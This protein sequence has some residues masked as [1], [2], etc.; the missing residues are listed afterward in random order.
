MDGEEDLRLRQASGAGRPSQPGAPGGAPPSGSTGSTSWSSARRSTPPRRAPSW[1]SRPRWSSPCS[2]TRPSPSSPRPHPPRCCCARR[3][4]SRREAGSR[5]SPRSA[6]SAAT[7]SP[8]VA[9]V[10]MPDLNTSDEDAANP[11]R[12]GDRP[13]HGHRDRGSRLTCR[14]GVTR[15][16]EKVERGRFYEATE[17]LRLLKEVANPEVRRDRGGGGEPGGGPPASPTRWCAAR[18]CCRTA[19]AGMVRV[20][21]LRLRAPSRRRGA[22]GRRGRRGS[23]G[24]RGEGARRRD[25]VRRGDRHTRLHAESWAS[26]GRILGPRGLMPNPKTGTVTDD[27]TTAV[28]NAKGGQVQYRTDRAGDHPLPHRQALVRRRGPS[29]EPRRP[30]RAARAGEA[31]RRQG[32]IS[33]QGDRLQHHGTGNRR[34]Q[35]EPVGLIE[36]EPRT[37]GAAP[38]APPLAAVPLPPAGGAGASS[39]MN[40]KVRTHAVDPDAEEG[41]RGRGGRGS[42]RAPLRSWP[43]GFPRAQRR[44]DDGAAESGPRGRRVPAGRAQQPRAGGRWSPPNSSACARACAGRWCWRSPATIQARRP[45]SSAIT[46][47]SNQKLEIRLAAFGG[48]PIDPADIDTLANIPT[49]DEAIAPSDDRAHGSGHEARPDPGRT[50]M[51]GS[52][53]RWARSGIGRRRRAERARTGPQPP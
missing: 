45:A 30:G 2:R 12:H 9:R 8:R 22:R 6:G 49:R 21:V 52:S 40:W 43:A 36:A 5:T 37:R 41:G 31:G 32:D 16:R 4:G 17:A 53:G 18:R 11:H 38:A 47:A 10:K 29:G 26:S 3:W 50:P 42:R 19:P 15:I 7:R 24:P 51:P 27:V 34:R 20:A 39:G 44:R 1:A 48:K 13:Q 23:R 28:A 35:G 14:N 25:R 46:G 33:P